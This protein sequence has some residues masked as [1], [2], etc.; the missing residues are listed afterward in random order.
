MFL[1]LKPFFLEYKK[2]NCVL[3][4]MYIYIAMFS[5]DM[6]H[7]SHSTVVVGPPAGPPT[8]KQPASTTH[9]TH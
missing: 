6:L 8:N 4:I 1:L 9:A 7:I 3:L 5:T 2:P